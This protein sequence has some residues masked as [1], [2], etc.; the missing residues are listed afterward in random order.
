M[1]IALFIQLKMAALLSLIVLIMAKKFGTLKTICHLLEKWT[2]DLPT[3]A[4]N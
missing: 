1:V 3:I 2:L 4:T